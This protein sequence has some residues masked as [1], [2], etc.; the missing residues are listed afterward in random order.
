MNSI[1]KTQNNLVVDQLPDGSIREIYLNEYSGNLY[2]RYK[3]DAWDSTTQHPCIHL[4]HDKDGQQYVIHNHLDSH[5]KTAIDT[6]DDFA[7]G[8]QV[9][10]DE[11]SCSNSNLKIIDNA[12]EQVRRGEKYNALFYNCQTTVNLAC[13]NVRT[14]ET[15]NKWKEIVTVAVLG[16]VV[17]NSVFGKKQPRNYR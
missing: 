9:Y 14:S 13:D 1:F 17:I 7:K 3:I 4:G 12:L 16:G 15:V 6:W 5:G 2:Y 10:L 11:R 8:Q